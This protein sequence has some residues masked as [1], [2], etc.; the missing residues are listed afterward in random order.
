MPFPRAAPSMCAANMSSRRRA[1]GFRRRRIEPAEDAAVVDRVRRCAARTQQL[2]VLLQG[3]QFAD[4]LLHM[5]DVLI[6]PR[7]DFSAV[8]RRQLAPAQQ[9]A[10]LVERH[11]PVPAVPDEGEAIGM[12]CAADAVVVVGTSR[13]R[14]EA[15][16]LAEADGLDGDTGGC[17][18]I[19]DA[20]GVFLSTKRA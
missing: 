4:A 5:P 12:C 6:E 20:H 8:A 13:R 10:D 2:Q 15:L 16:A 19:A 9:R 3:S 18:Q 7:I 1:A 11:V 17:R 14:Q